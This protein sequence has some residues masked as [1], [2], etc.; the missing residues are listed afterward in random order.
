MK[1]IHT[2]FFVPLLSVFLSGCIYLV[3]GG[4]GALGG[5]IVSP[6]TVEGVADAELS[7]VWGTARD[8]VS[9]MGIV[10]SETKSGGLINARIHGAQVTVLVTPSGSSTVKVSVKARK[11]YLPKISLAQDIFVKIMSR[12]K[13]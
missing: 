11:H 8:V 5:Y 4:V 12:L 13:K 1:R 7:T 6:D 2:A 10:E 9:I 3:V